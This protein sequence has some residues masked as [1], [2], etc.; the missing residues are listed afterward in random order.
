MAHVKK[1]TANSVGGLSI[2]IDRKTTNHS[3]EDIDIERTPLNYDLCEKEG[4][5]QSR[6]HQRLSEVYCMKREDVKSCASWVVT[7]PEELLQSSSEEQKQFFEATYTFLSQHYGKENILSGMVHY[8]ETTPHIHFAFVPV[9]F[10]EKKQ[11]EKV[12]A[13]LVLTRKELQHFH[14]DLDDYLKE[15]IPMIYREGILNGKTIGIDDVKILK[16]K[17]SEVELKK[18]Q[19]NLS[20]QKLEEKIKVI[21]KDIN[22]F[23]NYKKPVNKLNHIRENAIN[24]P[25]NQYILNEK[26]FKEI[27]ELAMAGIKKQLGVNTIL[28]KNRVDIQTFSEQVTQ[29][30]ETVSR[31]E[32]ENSATDLIIESREDAIEEL[33]NENF[34]LSSRLKDYESNQKKVT[35]LEIKGRRILDRLEK[36]EEPQTTQECLD[37][38]NIL[39][40]NKNRQYISKNRVIGFIEKLKNIL[41]RLVH[42][43]QTQEKAEFNMD[44]LKEKSRDLR[45]SKPSKE[46]DLER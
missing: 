21:N 26:Q 18:E 4:D 25:F 30:K 9:V 12:S 45:Q 29:L 8:D 3:N 20:E 14:S 17:S 35:D 5:L 38:M 46:H 44:Y 7:L 37:W 36:G 40:T 28:E 1:F 23:K 16:E 43:E 41:K 22:S 10:D 19:L 15:K 34:I 32:T 39:E 24:L 13:K 33:A 27:E 11:R 6:Y 31:L 2:H 42:R